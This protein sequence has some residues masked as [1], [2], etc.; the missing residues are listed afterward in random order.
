VSTGSADPKSIL[1]NNTN[2]NGTGITVNTNAA[3]QDNSFVKGIIST[4]QPKAY[5]GYFDGRVEATTVLNLEETATEPLVSNSY[6]GDIYMDD[7]ANT[8][9]TQR[10]LRYFDGTNWAGLSGSSGL[11]ALDEGN[12]IGWRLRGRDPA[13]YGNIGVDAV[14][15]SSSSSSITNGASGRNSFATG[16]QTKASG[17]H[18]TAL[19]QFTI[20]SGLNSTALGRS[21][22]ASGNNSTSI[23]FGTNAFGDYSTSMG[24]GTNA[25]G[26][27]S[28]SMGLNTNAPS[29]AET[30]IGTY[31]TT[32]TP[33][34][35]TTWNASDRLFVVGNGQDSQNKSDVFTIRKDGKATINGFTTINS[36]SFGLVINS[37]S[38]ALVISPGTGPT[39]DGVRIFSAGDDG[40]HIS[41]AGDNGVEVNSAG[42]NGVIVNLADRNGGF[43][44]GITSGVHAESNDDGNPD[45]ILGGTANTGAGDDGIIASDPAYTSS[46]IW[47]RSND[48]VI[49]QLD[50]D[51]NET[52]QFE[53]W[54]ASD[55]EVFEVDES[56]TVRVNG[57]VEHS[58][59]RRLKKD[60]E[61]IPYGLKDILLL[62]PK[63]YNWKD[64][65]Q[66][67]KSLGLIAQEVQSVIK[68][69]VSEKDNEAKTLGVSYT[70]LI[71]VLINAIQEQQDFIKGQEEA[72]AD[73]KSE[74]ERQNSISKSLITRMEL[75]ESNTVV[76]KK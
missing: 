35:T 5:A 4:A 34:S 52:G 32:Y 10:G 73:L 12:G 33:N 41:G 59:D 75:L 14:D 31:N 66:T 40:L 17:V 1:V 28:T 25:S 70:E 7:G 44:R 42:D 47:L 29:Y 49:V 8:N 55:V 53:I 30:A 23:G 20:A 26:D 46:D 21:T 57:M 58:S 71:P 76:A 13:N 27:Y 37:D 36:N 48:A 9:D 54:N 74:L 15:L 72:I 24:Y 18:S 69:V 16:N 2:V 65:T 3:A 62:Q 50:I 60:I 68:E 63:A 6:A 39:D 43:F 61:V 67:H 56:G 11:Q 22:F 45:I 51:K 19:G 38:D 64:R